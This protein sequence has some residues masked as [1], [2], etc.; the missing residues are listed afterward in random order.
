MLNSCAA[1]SCSSEDNY[2]AMR[3]LRESVAELEAMLGELFALEDGGEG[4]K[5]KSL[6][7]RKKKGAIGGSGRSSS[8]ESAVVLDD[9]DDDDDDEDLVADD[10]GVQRVEAHLKRTEADLAAKGDEIVQLQSKVRIDTLVAL[11]FTNNDTFQLSLME[12]QLNSAEEERESLRK[13]L[14]ESHLGKD[15]LVR[16]AWDARDAAVKRKNAAEVELAKERI[17]IMQVRDR[18]HYGTI[19]WHTVWHTSVT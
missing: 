18:L 9:D 1:S 8:A 13:E 6:R 10:E 17:G 12:T 2:E 14:H 5:P 15:E 4:E 11:Y 16:K 19:L 7:R 3:T